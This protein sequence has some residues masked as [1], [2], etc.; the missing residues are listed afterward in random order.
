MTDRTLL[1]SA[2][3]NA[4]EELNSEK[5]PNKDLNNLILV[6]SLINSDND[7]NLSISKN[8]TD[9]VSYSRKYG[10][11]NKRISTTLARYIRRQLKMGVSDITDASLDAFIATVKK[12][13][14]RKDIE[15]DIRIVTGPDVITE[16][17]NADCNSHSCM[18][19]SECEKVELYALNPDKVSLILYKN[20]RALLW[21]C[22]D[23][24]YVLDR[25]YPAQCHSIQI[26]RDWAESKGYVLRKNSDRVVE[27][28]EK[29]HLTDGKIHTV[30]L[31]HKDVYP[32]MDTFVYSKLVDGK[33]VAKNDPKF[34]NMIL[35]NIYGGYEKAKVCYCCDCRITSGEYTVASDGNMYCYTCFDK[36]FFLCDCCGD[37]K[38]LD[39]NRNNL[40]SGYCLCDNCISKA[41]TCKV[42]GR[43]DYPVHMA[44]VFGEHYCYEC[45]VEALEGCGK[46]KKR[47]K[48]DYFVVEGICKDCFEFERCSHCER[49]IKEKDSVFIENGKVICAF[50]GIQ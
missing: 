12:V 31:K 5:I 49:E 36:N 11:G 8:D 1:L 41:V 14:A 9:K 23:G 39:D 30:T 38:V 6:E 20:A 40:I 33:L 42:C 26:I 46:C 13:I 21:V 17:R 2:I 44:D 32:Y 22:D 45:Y 47:F 35:H 10:G 4:I 48:K 19:G 27:T 34:G 7:K 18:T 24:T 50:C 28:G 3:N 16:Y 43:K 37:Y 15:K 29:A 25:I